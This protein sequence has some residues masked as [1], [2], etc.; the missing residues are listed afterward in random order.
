MI[1][2]NKSDEDKRRK[3]RSLHVDAV[4]T[5]T[6][7]VYHPDYQKHDTG[8][9]HPERAERL[10]AIM[11]KLEGA[12]ITEKV[13]RITPSKATRAQIG[14][15]HRDAH[16]LRVD[17]ICARGGGMLDPDTPVCR[18]SCEVALLAAGGVLN[19]VDAVMADKLKYVFALI[20][21]PG[22]HATSNKGMGFCIYNNIAI[23]AQHLKRNHGVRRILIVDWDVHHGNGTQEVFFDDPS[24]LYFSMH[25]YPYYPG[26]G[27]L[28][29]VGKG[30]GEGFTVNVPLHAGT[31]DTGYLY[32]LEHILVPIATNFK[33]EFVLVSAGFDAH[34]ADPLASMNV[35]SHGFGLFAEVIKEIAAE[36]SNGKVVIALEGGY[37][38]NALAES[39]SSVFEALFSTG[40]RNDK[41]EEGAQ[42][43]VRKRVEEIKQVQRNYWAYI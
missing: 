27:W 15:V 38:L 20:R 39:V 32:V 17:S 28:D 3:S 35:T 29:E 12:G 21:P 13:K 24:V 9:A 22:H 7:L 1:S 31:D 18:D 33:P 36:N 2:Y 16:I 4:R 25:Q 30:D 26:T 10:I 8:A 34:I 37:N 6:G 23:A 5:V 11:Q 19:A 40:K 42:E 14:Y 43:K 41:K